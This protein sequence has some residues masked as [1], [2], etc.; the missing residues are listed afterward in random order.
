MET[1][2]E[3]KLSGLNRKR[4]YKESKNDSFE[5]EHEV[6]GD[7][8]GVKSKNFDSTF[9]SRNVCKKDMKL[10]TLLY[11]IVDDVN[12]KEL[13]ISL[14]GLNKSIISV[15]N[16][17]EDEE[18]LEEF[19]R[20]IEKLGL[21]K[22]FTIGQPVNCA[23]ISNNKTKNNLTIKPSILNAGLNSNS[24]CF[25]VPGYVISGLVLSKENHGY[26][27]YTGIKGIKNVFMKLDNCSDEYKL[28]QIL[29]LNVS[30]YYKERS[31][32]LCTPINHDVGDEGSVI[33]KNEMLSI[34]EIKPGLKLECLIHS[35]GESEDRSLSNKGRG[36]NIISVNNPNKKKKLSQD[37]IKKFQPN[38]KIL[39]FKNID[40]NYLNDK[41][42]LGIREYLQEDSHS[43][44]VSFCMGTMLGVIPSEHSIH[45]LSCLNEE[46]YKSGLPRE[47]NRRSIG[48]SNVVIARIIAVI[49]DSNN[50]IVLSMLPHVIESKFKII[51]DDLLNKKVIPILSKN[52]EKDCE[53]VS[54][55]KTIE[56]VDSMSNI[57]L[58]SGDN[59]E[60]K[61]KNK[62]VNF[63]SNIGNKWY[64]M[65][66]YLQSK[67]SERIDQTIRNNSYR[68]IS[69]SR[70]ENSYLVSFDPKIVNERY[71]SMHDIS[72]GKIVD[73]K[74]VEINN[75][76]LSVRLS[77][78]FS[79]RIYMEH[80][81]NCSIKNQ[82]DANGN[83]GMS[84]ERMNYI[85]KNYQIGREYKFRILRYEYSDRS[86]NP[87]L[88]LTAK[89]AL[90]NDKLPIITSIS[91]ELS[92]GQVAVG[93][94][95]R[96]CLVNNKQENISKS[97][98]SYIIIR[99][100]GEA[101]GSVS[102]N[103]YVNYLKENESNTDEEGISPETPRIGDIV[104]V[105]ISSIDLSGDNNNGSLKLSLNTSSS[106]WVN[107]SLPLNIKNMINQLKLNDNTG[108]FNDLTIPEDSKDNL[109]N[110]YNMVLVG[111]TREG[112]LFIKDK[113]ELLYLARN[114]ISDNK[115]NSKLVFNMLYELCRSSKSVGDL[116]K[117]I[118]KKVNFELSSTIDHDK[119]LRKRIN[120]LTFKLDGKRGE[121]DDQCS[122]ELSLSF[123]NMNLMHSLTY[124][125][126]GQLTKGSLCWSYVTH[127]DKYGLL[128][129]IKDFI[130]NG[131]VG[132]KE[133]IESDSLSGLVPRHLLSSSI[134]F[135]S[136]E[137]L[138]KHFEIG[139]S[140]LLR[141]ANI[142]EG[143]KGENGVDRRITFSYKDVFSMSNG[144]TGTS[145]DKE[146]EVINR[147]FA[148]EKQDTELI[149]C[150]K[151]TL[152]VG[153]TDNIVDKNIIGKVAEFKIKRKTLLSKN[154]DFIVLAS[155]DIDGNN[156]EE[157]YLR[158]L[159]HKGV[160]SKLD[161]SS[162]NGDYD[163]KDEFFGLVLGGAYTENIDGNNICY[164]YNIVCISDDVKDK[165]DKTGNLLSICKKEGLKINDILFSSDET[166]R[167]KIKKSNIV[168]LDELYCI[169]LLD[170]SLSL[171][172]NVSN[173]KIIKLSNQLKTIPIIIYSNRFD[174]EENVSGFECFLFSINLEDVP[175]CYS[176]VLGTRSSP[177]LD[178]DNTNTPNANIDD[179]VEC[180]IIDHMNMYN[181][182]I[183][184]LKDKSFGRIHILELD[185]DNLDKP[186]SVEKY[187]IGNTIKGIIYNKIDVNR[188]VLLSKDCC[189]SRLKYA[190]LSWEISSKV[191]RIRKIIYK[192]EDGNLIGVINEV[193]EITQGS[194]LSGYIS[195]S[196]R[197]GV[198]VRYGLGNLVGRIKLRELTS[199]TITPDEAKNTFYPGRYIKQMIVTN[200][201]DDNKVDL[202]LSKLQ[203]D[204]I[205]LRISQLDENSFT[206]DIDME[207]DQKEVIESDTKVKSGG[208]VLNDVNKKLNFDDLYIGRV[209][210]GIVKSVSKK[211]GLFIR[212]TDLKGDVVALSKIKECLDTE[213]DGNTISSIFNIGD[214][215]LCKVIKLDTENKKVWV[216]IKPSYFEKYRIEQDEDYDSNAIDNQ[217]NK[218]E[219]EPT[220][221]NKKGD[222]D[223]IV[224][225][226]V[227]KDNYS[228][229]FSMNENNFV[230]PM[231]VESPGSYNENLGLGSSSNLH[232]DLD[233][234]EE[235]DVNIQERIKSSVKQ[236]LETKNL[237]R[238]KKVQK[239]LEHEHKLR[240]EE[241]KGMY[242]HLNPT[243]IDEFER[244]L[245]TNK[246]VSSIWIKYMSYY[247]DTGELDKA[248]AVAERSLKQISVKEE[249]ERWNVWIAYIN[250]EIVYGGVV[251]ELKSDGNVD[252]N[253]KDKDIH[254]KM[255]ENLNSVIE[256]A[257]MNVYD[258][259][260]LY[261][262]IFN[263]F[264]KYSNEEFGISV[265]LQGLKKF[266]S[267]RKLWI[268]YL[269][270]LYEN[271]NQRKAR[272]EVI[273]KS[274]R[275]V[276]K[277]KLVRLI[278]DIARLEF[279]HGNINRGRTIFENL[280]D[281][282]VKRMDLWSQYFDILTK[283]CIKNNS[284][285]YIEM[286]RSIYRSTS[287]NKQFKPRSMKMIFTRWLA[288]EK[289][290]GNSSSQ[291]N[292]QELAINYV[293]NL[294]S[295]L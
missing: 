172:N 80:L 122:I 153:K 96:I 245:V 124:N 26:V 187:K 112:I 14:P 240:Q 69:Y 219:L 67:D 286:V 204:D 268:T 94:I 82:T 89:R 239:Q 181:G 64:S 179:V 284:N 185:D 73:A 139:E 113:K 199:G 259:K 265:L 287:S 163:I 281:E 267:S 283:L 186:L 28:G 109:L 222:E 164:V 157:V 27:V 273:Q 166:H 216:G 150:L 137:E 138:S 95:S 145:I 99:F 278:T 274:L 214:N 43:L 195:N 30:M 117:K 180:K 258:Q 144:S 160:F 292:V 294:E 251:K 102:Y 62:G 120:L 191:S 20:S 165:Y 24:K 25:E 97:G 45:P 167:Y 3:G 23:I 7:F 55:L 263:S 227:S 46:E 200:I 13:I 209:L 15:E 50:K 174:K 49:S 250:M 183:V 177:F 119:K 79:G 178:K 87:L 198:F 146:F 197:E 38:T 266:P 290:F 42:I 248:R 257:L 22:R 116:N 233:G 136:K 234:D 205:K 110:K 81:F 132:D 75:W 130:T 192:D 201:G 74:I 269:T 223:N 125:I 285:D 171:S 44:K 78:Y 203:S 53:L 272:D 18:S 72:P 103:E 92:V 106:K 40:K 59:S 253:T 47:F 271:D 143:I 277:D 11:G 9:S 176:L 60:N 31:L 228:L 70:L 37:N 141:V 127:I 58:Y 189:N 149:H 193:R 175:I 8:V 34:Y 270:S 295:K 36:K 63:L 140:L 16:T 108:Y 123:K 33:K 52:V 85:K 107:D 221:P 161:R 224:D 114:A 190:N 71:F 21:N 6:L 5:E 235:L 170:V 162:L 211:Y 159:N 90:I 152:G 12:E 131:S 91:N 57:T 39:Q 210:S 129:S 111:V 196:G 168:Y 126:K 93:Y 118:S 128:V 208:L 83:K 244:T 66:T 88:L 282:N 276:S 288:F 289:Q 280:L 262:Q 225:I 4:G 2:K 17:I 51:N 41:E 241:E 249:M 84:K 246:D 148:S 147:I 100:Y 279:E 142:S 264:K 19:T 1:I 213:C 217:V 230:Y 105:R 226:D 104:T 293:S 65:C 169:S 29:V 215:L 275:S 236:D 154:D 135:E 206:S 260:K 76:G 220:A 212:L 231:R 158:L 254:M 184:Q 256:R 156:S 77:D 155:V 35:Y 229:D 243:T 151:K 115:R 207:I 291:K 242:S 61:S 101:Y 182:L 218:I 86:W 173:K 232:S 133:A 68:I 202:S 252:E 32:L 98:G 261:I 247:L 121:K 48:L 237:N 10:G 54:N 255:R 56:S 188:K 194:I 134:Y 238:N